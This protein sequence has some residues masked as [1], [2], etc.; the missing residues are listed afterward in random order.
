MLPLNLIQKMRGKMEFRSS[1]CQHIKIECPVVDKMLSS[2]NGYSFP[3]GNSYQAKKSFAE[4]WETIEFL[5]ALLG[6]PDDMTETSQSSFLN[7]LT[8]SEQLSFQET[9]RNIVWIGSDATM[10]RCGAIDFSA[11]IYIFFPNGPNSQDFGRKYPLLRR[12]NYCYFRILQF[13]F[14]P[15]N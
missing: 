1:C 9:R 5:R 15:F 3:K 6:S 11:K 12:A 2:K 14:L 10:E 13:D 4:F 7:V 8:I